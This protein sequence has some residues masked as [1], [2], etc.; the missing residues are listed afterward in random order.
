[1]KKEFDLTSHVLVP[2]HILMN[3][4][5]VEELLEKYKITLNEL[6]RISLKDPVVAKLNASLDDV[7]KIIRSSST[8]GESEFY[9]RVV[10]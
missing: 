4:K 10:K 3:K 1:M 7:V 9:R 2:K 5:E 6:P 8:S